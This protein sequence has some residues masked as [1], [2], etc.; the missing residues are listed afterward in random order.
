LFDVGSRVYDRFEMGRFQAMNGLA[1]MQKLVTWL[2]SANGV[3]ILDN[4]ESVTGEPLAIPNTLNSTEQEK[5]RDFLSRLVGGKSRVLLGSRSDEG[6]L[7]LVI[8]GNVYGL[9]GLDPEAR[10]DLAKEILARHARSRAEDL[11]KDGDFGRLL[12]VLAGYPLAMEVVLPN[13]SRQSPGEVLTALQAAD[14]DLDTGSE[15]RTRS[16]LKCV[17]YSHSNLSQEAQRLLLCLAPF[18]G[19]IWR[20]AIPNYAEELRKLEPF[21]DYDFSLFDGAIQE[22]I[23]WGLLEPMDEEQQLLTIQPV[24][25]YFLKTKLNALETATREA[26]QTGFKNHYQGLADSYKQLMKS[27]EPQERQLGIFFCRLEYENLYNALFFAL[28]RFESVFN[29][30]VCLIIYFDLTNDIQGNLKFSQAICARLETYPAESRSQDIELQILGLIDNI[31]KSYLLLEDYQQARETYRKTFSILTEFENLPQELKQNLTATTYHQLGMVA[32]ELREY[33]EARKNY[34]QALAIN[35]EFGDRYNQ[36][37]TY[38]QLGIVAQKL[39]EYEEARN[40]YQQALAILVEFGDRYS[41]ASTYLQLGTVALELREY[42]EARKNY[43]QALAINVEFGDRYSQHH[44]SHQLGRVAQELRE[45]EEARKNYQ[46]ALA[47]NVEFGDRYSQHH[48]YHQLG[49]VAQELREYE[50][51]RKNYQQALAIKVEFGDRYNQAKTYHQLGRVA[52][53]LREYAEARN[54]YQQAL[55]IWVEFGDRYSQASTHHQLGLVA[56]ELREYEEA[57]NNYQQALAIKV[58][59]GDRYSQANTYHNLGRVAED[60]EEFPEAKIN[61]LQALSIYAEFNAQYMIE[62][63]SIPA[64]KRLYQATQ[65]PSI[66][67]VIAQLFGTNIDQIATLFEEN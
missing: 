19:F 34:Q 10:T 57:R 63:Y 31:A 26:L 18:S 64:L 20:D 5:L 62:T 41:Q 60:L 51:A 37:K 32:D 36:A 52:E 24:F 43:Q 23:H 39:R 47:I 13:L 3:L 9:R 29:L 33:E 15:D 17:E 59:F 27:Q 6:W 40:D 14:V 45:Y 25:P 22:A 54:N 16:I 4:L 49:R 11:F 38:H 46:Q 28:D 55:A 58:E 35:V 21:Q 42:E 53:E 48:Q 2:R 56:Q 12:K 65:D 8:R 66:L 30:V 61:F 50:E 7:G 44:Q 1:Q 67:E